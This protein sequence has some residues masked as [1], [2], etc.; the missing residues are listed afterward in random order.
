MGQT[1]AFITIITGELLR[2]YSARSETKTIFQ[3]N[4]FENKLVNYSVVFGLALLLIVI[5]V[6]GI[7]GL[8]YTNVNLQ[9]IELLTA[10]SLGFIPLFGGELAK[11]FK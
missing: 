3:M 10:L 8:F 11:L 1:F 5:Y 2:S 7:N 4:I 9:F 6:P